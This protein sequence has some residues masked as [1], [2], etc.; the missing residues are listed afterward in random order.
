[1]ETKIE[2]ETPTIEEI[3]IRE[4]THNRGPMMVSQLEEAKK[5]TI[6]K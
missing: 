4:M 5:S 6:V 2:E 3:T 1:V